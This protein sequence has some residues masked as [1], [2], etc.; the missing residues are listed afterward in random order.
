MNKHDLRVL[1]E[2]ITGYWFHKINDLPIGADLRVDI[3]QRFSYKNLEIIFDVG[4]NIGQTYF[5]FKRDFPKAKIYCFEPVNTTFKKLKEN[6]NEDNKIVL[7]NF[8]FGEAAGEKQ[9]RLFNGNNGLNSLNEESMNP[10]PDAALQMIKIETIDN[11]CKL[12]NIKKIDLLKIDTEGYEINVLK[13]AHDLLSVK[14]ISFV[15]CEA[16]FLKNN[17]RHTN[18]S[19]AAEF[20]AAYNYYFVGLYNG[21]SD[22]WRQGL[23]YGNALFCHTALPLGNF[24]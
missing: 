5:Y 16:G 10:L 22:D 7:E 3:T 1:I 9:I 2:K 19:E 12:H 23:Y 14:K 21:S 6:V 4:A 11:Y 17:K 24:L 20:L 8:A 18:F 13:G 15:Y